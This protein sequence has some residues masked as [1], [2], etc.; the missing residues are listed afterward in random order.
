[1]FLQ[2]FMDLGQSW[3][4]KADRHWA[5]APMFFLFLIFSKTIMLRKTGFWAGDKGGAR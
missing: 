4:S 5:H 1:M 3:P 2:A